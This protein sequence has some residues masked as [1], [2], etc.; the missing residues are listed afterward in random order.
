MYRAA[1]K[2]QVMAR[3]EGGA[4][5]GRMVVVFRD[6]C[7]SVYTRFFFRLAHHV[8]TSYLTRMKGNELILF[9]R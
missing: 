3:G 2:L 9:Q 5:I 7:T 8:Y 1:F 4:G 6:Q